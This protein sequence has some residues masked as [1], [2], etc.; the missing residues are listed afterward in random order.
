MISVGDKALQ[1]LNKLLIPLDGMKDSLGSLK[2]MP[3]IIAAI[4][5]AMT[6]KNKGE[7]ADGFIGNSIIA[8]C[9]SN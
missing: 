8:L 9:S 3:S 5:A 6:I 4:S 2:A 1:V 7:A